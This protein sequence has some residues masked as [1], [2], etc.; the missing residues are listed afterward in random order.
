[1]M[2]LMQLAYP[3]APVFHSNLISLMD[4]R[5]GGYIGEVP[6]P[7]SILMVQ[8]AHAWG[9]PTLGGGSVSSD[10]DVIGWQ[11][12]QEAGMGAALIPLAGGEVC[13]YLGMMGSSMILYPEEIILEYEI[14]QN[15]VDSFRTYQVD[16]AEFPFDVIKDVGP[17]GHYLRQKHTRKHMRDFRYSTLVR[18]K[19]ANGKPRD[20]V[21]VALEEFK[22]IKKT[23]HPEPLPEATLK[24][25]DKILESAER[26]AEKLVV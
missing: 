2:V 20:P 7:L 8:L 11:S 4:P 10:S 18:E 12:G 17:G 15:V 22:H 13:G 25:L 26:E 16:P 1:M 9:V 24:E 5:T 6:F 3:G 19:D 23:H 21:D 14:I